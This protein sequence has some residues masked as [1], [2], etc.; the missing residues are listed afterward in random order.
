M[1]L[2]LIMKL[3]LKLWQKISAKGPTRNTHPPQTFA[4]IIYSPILVLCKSINFQANNRTWLQWKCNFYNRK[5]SF[6]H[7]VVIILLYFVHFCYHVSLIV[8]KKS[9]EFIGFVFVSLN[10]KIGRK[11]EKMVK[12]KQFKR[13][14]FD[15]NK[16]LV[17]HIHSIFKIWFEF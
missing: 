6:R 16:L 11:K 12:R 17:C 8:I 13:K 15:Y 9:L 10:H 4:F 7:F 1:F 5:L 3:L 2:D 14:I